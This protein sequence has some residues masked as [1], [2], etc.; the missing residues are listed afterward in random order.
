MIEAARCLDP[1]FCSIKQSQEVANLARDA[2]TPLVNL[3]KSLVVEVAKQGTTTLSNLLLDADIAEEVQVEDIILP[4]TR[5]L[6][7]GNHDGKTHAAAAIA[8]LLQS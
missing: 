3:A 6:Q 1:I 7:E 8:C 4:I 2:L 5:V